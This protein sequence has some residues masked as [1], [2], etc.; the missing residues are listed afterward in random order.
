MHLQNYTNNGHTALNRK[1]A[2]FCPNKERDYTVK[3]ALSG[4]PQ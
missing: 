1:D 3:P 2:Q 4:H